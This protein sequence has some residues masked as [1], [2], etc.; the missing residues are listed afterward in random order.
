MQISGKGRR[1]GFILSTIYSGSALKLWHKLIER[2][3]HDK[4]AF[5]VFPGGKLFSKNG[6]EQ[7]RNSVYELVNS[8]NLD[9]LIS[10]ASSISGSVSVNEV[11]EFHSRFKE[12]PM[13]TIGQKLH[14]IPCSEF[15]AYT[16]MKELVLHFIK[17]HD[18]KKIAFLRGPS[19]HTSAED[20]FR[21]FKDALSDAGLYTEESQKL[22][23]DAMGWSDG[24]KAIIQLC[25]ERNLVPGKDFE[26]LIGASDLMTFAAVNY[27][28]KRGVRIP[29]DLLVGGFND[30]EESRI[31]LPA[32]STV[33]MPNAELGVDAYEKISNILDGMLGVNDKHLT[34][35]P[36]FR[37]S[38]GC[39]RAKIWNSS[40]SKYRIR[41]EAQFRE[42]LFKIFHMNPEQANLDPMLRALFDNDKPK[43]YELFTQWITKYFEDGGESLTVFTFLSTLRGITNLAPEYIE[44][45]ILIL[46]KSIATASI[47][48]LFAHLLHADK[49][50]SSMKH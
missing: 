50:R 39:N 33:H 3:S 38:C 2:A 5:F 30:T 6:T 26:A 46:K 1:I 19:S 14:G 42:E 29:K 18:V 36:V 27:L 45:V 23:T 16:G 40:D 12:I 28:K 32:F 8:S 44:K 49:P 43:F 11:E 21:G 25:E 37:E 24:E 31:S 48:Q 9:G 10:W 41:N 34:A 7:L 15:D 13:V 17:N 4:G 47:S 35:Y 22:I 20:R